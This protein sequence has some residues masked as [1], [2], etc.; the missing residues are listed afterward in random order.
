M[1]FVT[2]NVPESTPSYRVF[3]VCRTALQYLGGP[4]GPSL[5]I[6]P[7]LSCVGTHTGEGGGRAAA[8]RR[9]GGGL[10]LSQRSARGLARDNQAVR[11]SDRPTDSRWSEEGGRGQDSLARRPLSLSLSLSLFCILLLLLLLLLLL[12]VCVSV[13][14]GAAEEGVEGKRE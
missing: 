10:L 2:S 1:I 5:A 9:G 14:G 8:R 4:K 7:L 13:R 6:V 3:P 11:P 12:D